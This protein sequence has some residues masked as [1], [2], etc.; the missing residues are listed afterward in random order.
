MVDETKAVEAYL[1]QVPEPARTTLSKVRAMI[2]AAAPKEATEGISYGMPAFHYKGP[3]VGYKASA[4]H[5]ALYPMSGATVDA[6]RKELEDVGDVIVHALGAR[7]RREAKSQV[8][9]ALST[10]ERA[11]A[12]FAAAARAAGLARQALEMATLAYKAGATTNIEVIDAERSARDAEADA[13]QA[14]DAARRARLD[15]LA[16]LG[17]LKP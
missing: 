9:V 8:R 7:S 13:V 4:K 1:A 16:A 15:L 17:H 12:S 6:H 5:C 3:L 2:R 11:E 10:V 14:E